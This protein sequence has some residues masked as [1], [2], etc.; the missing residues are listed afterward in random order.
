MTND[1]ISG[2]IRCYAGYD[3][4]SALC[5][6]NS[7]ASGPDLSKKLK[8][9][10]LPEDEAYDVLEYVLPSPDNWITYI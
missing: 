8:G 4:G 10:R 9:G 7:L 2:K 6:F 5:F 1:T 3:A